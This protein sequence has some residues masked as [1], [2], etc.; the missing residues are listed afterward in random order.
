MGKWNIQS[1]FHYGRHCFHMSLP[2]T[3]KGIWKTLHHRKMNGYTMGRHLWFLPTCLLCRS[4]PP[5]LKYLV[6]GKLSA[7]FTRIII[8]ITRPLDLSRNGQPKADHQA[9]N[10]VACTMVCEWVARGFGGL[11]ILKHVASALATMQNMHPERYR[12][13]RSRRSTQAYQGHGYI[14]LGRQTVSSHHGMPLFETR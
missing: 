13:T 3:Q 5:I 8:E 12:K 2:K 4:F 14:N 6:R 10:G 9:L 11:W 7:E 1:G